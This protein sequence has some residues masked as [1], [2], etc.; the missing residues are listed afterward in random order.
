MQLEL[1]KIREDGGTQPREMFHPGVLQEYAEDMEAG[2]IFPPVIVFYDG[3]DYWL[4]DGFHRVT[5]ARSIGAEAIEAEVHQGT[6]EQAQWYS[7]SVNATHGKRRTT[8]DKQR[9]V[10]AALAHPKAAGMSDEA[11]AL[12]CGVSAPTIAKYRNQVTI[13]ILGSTGNGYRTGKDGVKRKK[14]TKKPPAPKP[15]PEDDEPL[16]E[17]EEQIA[18]QY[19]QNGVT[20]PISE[21]A[22]VGED[23]LIQIANDLIA[24]LNYEDFRRL[25]EIMAERIAVDV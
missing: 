3:T 8:E 24:K 21:P 4:V 1:S 15:E 2:A 20:A 23:R 5:A 9:A 19:Q 12:H 22:G 10:K 11:I 17:Y 7:Y 25:V 13:K 14:P 16:T 6:L 18:A